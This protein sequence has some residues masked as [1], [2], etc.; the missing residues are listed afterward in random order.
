MTQRRIPGSSQTPDWLPGAFGGAAAQ[1]VRLRWGFANETWAGRLPDG[2]RV[3]ATLLADPAAAERLRALI[4]VVRPR[5]V[6]A[7]LP[8]PAPIDAGPGVPAD[9]V[10]AEFV[11]G[12]P[13]P[14]ILGRADG[15]T[16]IGTLLGSAWRRLGTVDPAGTGLPDRWTSA[17]RLLVLAAGWSAIVSHDLA[18]PDRDRLDAV[19]GTLPELLVGRPAGVVHGD[20]VPAN[21]LVAD[22]RLVALLDLEAAR[23][24]DPLL[25]AAWFD[26]IVRY[27][28]PREEPAAWAAFAAEAGIERSDPTIDG[29]LHAYPIVRILEILDDI[30][31]ADAARPRWLGQL[32]AALALR[33]P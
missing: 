18:A 16:A 4:A 12:I 23:L 25:D 29:L 14:E 10:I 19:L 31:A 6:A 22:G 32:T 28:H 30:G 3:A 27:H 2:R 11:D 9:V 15:P 26:W 1:A 33:S 21:I 20:L 17:D 5:L 8:V 13:G 24:A 7:G